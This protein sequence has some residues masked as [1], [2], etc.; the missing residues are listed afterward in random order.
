MILKSTRSALR[1]TFSGLI[2][3]F[4]SVSASCCD[5]SHGSY[6]T[7]AAARGRRSAIMCVAGKSGTAR[8]W[9]GDQFVRTLIHSLPIQLH[10]RL[11]EMAR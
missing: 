10:V 6:W 8:V 3:R 1:V 2:C 4:V 9:A 7:N 11:D 5:F